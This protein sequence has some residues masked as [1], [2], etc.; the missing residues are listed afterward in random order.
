MIMASSG[1]TYGHRL[2]RSVMPPTSTTSSGTLQDVPLG[3]VP[4]CRALG[5]ATYAHPASRPS[6]S[7]LQLAD[8]F[9]VH[10]W[11]KSDLVELRGLEPLTPTLPAR[12][13]GVRR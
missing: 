13:G 10:G 5:G 8:I 12:L 1:S 11:S 6:S 2:T 3:D 4:S 7:A 9:S